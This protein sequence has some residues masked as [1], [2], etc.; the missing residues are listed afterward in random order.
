[1]S[2]SFTSDDWKF[3]EDQI[4]DH[5]VKQRGLLENSGKTWRELIEARAK[6]EILKTLLDLPKFI[7]QQ[8][9]ANRG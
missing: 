5:L 2:V 8:T 1:M 9:S 7:A 6:I 4:K 3:T